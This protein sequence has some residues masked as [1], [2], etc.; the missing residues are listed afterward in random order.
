MS[1]TTICIHGTEEQLKA[2]EHQ[3]EVIEVLLAQTLCRRFQIPVSPEN[4]S[5]VAGWMS[6]ARSQGIVAYVTRGIRIETIN[7]QAQ[8]PPSATRS[9]LGDLRQMALDLC[10]QIEESGASPELTAI[11]V[12]AA[13]LSQAI[14]AR[15]VDGVAYPRLTA[16][17]TGAGWQLE[18]E[19]QLGSY[20]IVEYPEGWPERITTEF[21]VEKGFVIVP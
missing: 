2:F 6:T 19:V 18:V 12:K 10:Y 9:Q 4:L 1:T 14:N 11:S 16:H 15:M 20:A 13:E 8:P 7:D 3:C 21:L 5:M 17:N